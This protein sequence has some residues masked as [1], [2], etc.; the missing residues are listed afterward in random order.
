M[1]NLLPDSEVKFKDLMPPNE[2]TDNK[3][4][5]VLICTL[6]AWETLSNPCNDVKL[7]APE[8]CKPPCTMRKPAEYSGPPHPTPLHLP[9]SGLLVPTPPHPKW[10]Y[11]KFTGCF[12]LLI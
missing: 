5:A 1:L 10:R 4:G 2:A 8:M 7:R 11:W 9:A 3:L 6:E 12:H